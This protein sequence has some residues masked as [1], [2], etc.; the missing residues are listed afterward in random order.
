MI[1]A[2]KMAGQAKKFRAR[3]LGLEEVFRKPLRTAIGASLALNLVSLV[4]P[5]YM[6]QIYDRVMSSRSEATLLA[7]TLITLV[8][9]ALF[10]VLD[11]FRNIIFARASASLYAELEA[12]VFYG[13]RAM[14]LGGGSGR[15]ARPI[16][17]LETV[18]AFLASPTPG[19]LF[20]LLFVPL[21]VTVLFLI[22]P[23]LGAVTIGFVVALAVLA[24]VN[25]S[26]M[27][28]STE[29]SVYHMRQATDMAEAYLRAVEPAI[30]MGFASAGERRAAESNREAV[31]SQVVAATT[32]GGIT[33]II[34]G[35]RQASQIVIMAV[36]A[37]LALE[38]S[39][40]MGS[41]I[42]A[43]LL[44]TKSL[45]PI[46]QLVSGWRQLFIVR[47]AW[48][49]L[50]GVIQQ[51]PEKS[52]AM[53]LPRPKGALAVEGV[54]ATAPESNDLILKGVSFAIKAGQSLAIVGPSGSGKSTLARVILG[55]WPVRQGVVRLDGAD[56]SRLD[57]DQVGPAIGY[58]P[59]NVD[60][61]PGTIAE[62]IRRLGPE[63]PDGV[64]EAATRAG[65]HP[66]I[67]ALPNG[68]DT[69][70]GAPGFALSGGQRQRIGLARALYGNPSLVVLDEPDAG[71]DRDGEVALGRAIVTLREQGATVIVIAHRPTL[72]HGLEMLLILQEG[73]VQKF[74]LVAELL[75][76]IAPTP[77]QAIRQ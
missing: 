3:L 20:D 54:V 67:L 76:Q 72:I 61:L 39:V 19:A 4:T 47:G 57:M 14:A 75:P 9:I 32:S 44:F 71:L 5:I 69:M 63:D 62:N 52:P 50:D 55:A 59:Q 64:V 49:R 53:P 7:I 68:Y 33:T 25:T 38:G 23:V 35:I 34:K 16:D 41:I 70:I 48:E 77:V 40:S 31:L 45:S 65:A 2:A 58:V 12:R 42:A 18:R 15:R 66:M 73:R 29:R 37:W 1:N 60:L 36:A 56:I 43:S 11:M 6:T 13:C 24:M 27:K 30:V 26:A 21:F 74:G 46:D 10:A 17:D 8:V 28:H 22:H 51:V